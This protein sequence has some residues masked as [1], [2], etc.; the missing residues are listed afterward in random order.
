[1]QVS[2]R[3]NNRG[4]VVSADVVES[5]HPAF[6]EPALAAVRQRKFDPAVKD[7][8]L[9]ESTEVVSVRIKPAKEKS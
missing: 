9:V 1:M 5:N 4:Q 8:H 6:A 2:C 3:I 7:R